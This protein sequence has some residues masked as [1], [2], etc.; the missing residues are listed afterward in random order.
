MTV[1]DILTIGCGEYKELV[2]VL[3]PH[4][5]TVLARTFFLSTY[6]R[7]YSYKYRLTGKFLRYDLAILAS[8]VL[9]TLVTIHILRHK[10]FFQLAKHHTYTHLMTQDIFPISKTPYRSYCTTH[11]Q[12]IFSN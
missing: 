5:T 6:G 2:F 1:A 10:T 7:S 4:L 3:V 9:P 11:S 12:D 8:E